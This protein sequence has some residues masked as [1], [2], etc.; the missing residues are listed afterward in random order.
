MGGVQLGG[1]HT[2]TADSRDDAVYCVYRRGEG[3]G[4]GLGNGTCGWAWAWGRP[5]VQCTY[6]DYVCLWVCVRVCACT[7]I[8]VGMIGM[9]YV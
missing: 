5:H 1:S 2:P 3:R 9:R 6:V 8:Y 7:C 4:E